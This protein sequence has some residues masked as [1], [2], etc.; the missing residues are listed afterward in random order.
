MVSN[1][2]SSGIKS[3]WKEHA[4]QAL[5]DS[6]I[7]K[8]MHHQQ[9]AQVVNLSFVYTTLQQCPNRDSSAYF[10]RGIGR[11]ERSCDAVAVAA[12]SRKQ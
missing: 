5:D 7:D 9:I 3:S 4:G 6:F 12:R 8:G 10:S 11:G 2:I 1:L